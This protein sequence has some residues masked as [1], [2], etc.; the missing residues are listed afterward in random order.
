MG[1]AGPSAN[2]RW[3]GGVPARLPHPPSLD[4]GS[5][6]RDGRDGARRGAS[7]PSSSLPLHTLKPQLSPMKRVWQGPARACAKAAGSPPGVRRRKA[8]TD[9]GTAVASDCGHGNSGRLP[10]RSAVEG[11]PRE[12]QER[13]PLPHSLLIFPASTLSPLPVQTPPTSSAVPR[14]GQPRES[15][16]GQPAGG[17]GRPAAGPPS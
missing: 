6:G 4:S 8:G 7:S 1:V 12:A 9:H 14:R 16:A 2:M 11:E 5:P 15:S 17:S 13:W 10:L 3:S